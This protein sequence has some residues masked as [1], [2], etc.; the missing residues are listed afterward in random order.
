MR[1][2]RASSSAAG[3]V[4]TQPDPGLA[5][6]VTRLD[7]AQAPRAHQVR[8][9]VQLVTVGPGSPP[10]VT[11]AHSG[12]QQ[13]P[14]P[15]VDRIRAPTR[16]RRADGYAHVGRVPPSRRPGGHEHATNRC[17]LGTTLVP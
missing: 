13:R 12:D 4:L 11:G 6:E 10:Q 8:I 7:P 9:D 15:P 14:Q 16:S 1:A 5:H 17:R 2:V 3:L